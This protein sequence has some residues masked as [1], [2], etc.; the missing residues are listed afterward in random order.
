VIELGPGTHAIARQHVVRDDVETLALRGAGPGETI[1]RG[2]LLLVAGRAEHVRISDL[3]IEGEALDVRGAA[4]VRFERVTFRGWETRAGYGAPVG[5]SGDALLSF[6][7]CTFVG[8]FRRPAGGHAIAVRGGVA[9][10]FTGCRFVDLDGV[11]AASQDAHERAMLHLSGCTVVR[12]E[13]RHFTARSVGVRVRDARTEPDVPRMRTGDLRALAEAFVPPP[14][15]RLV[16]VRLI[17]W[18]GCALPYVLYHVHGKERRTIVRLRGADV[19]PGAHDLVLPRDYA[20]DGAPPLLDLWPDVS[21][22]MP[23]D[24][25]VLRALNGPEGPVPAPYVLRS[26]TATRSTPRTPSPQR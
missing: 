4:S 1:V 16:G 24:G 26:T 7:D 21:D 8:G 6:R 23:A 19:T 11:V 5:A 25:V 3:T 13:L 9:A 10:L 18:E 17:D 2:D 12:G 14:G 22:D 15:E 20:P